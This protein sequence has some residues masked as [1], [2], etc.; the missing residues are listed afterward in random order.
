M[1]HKLRCYAYADDGSWQ[2]LCTDFDIAVEA[3]SFQEAKESLKICIQMYLEEISELPEV[4]RKRFLG[5][6]SP[7]HLRSKLAMK[8]WLYNIR[9]TP[10]YQEFF[11]SHHLPSLS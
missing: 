8:A 5:R 2:A 9:P 10:V 7:W 6:K 11:V 4:E 3:D 1:R